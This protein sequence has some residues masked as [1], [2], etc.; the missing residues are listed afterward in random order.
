MSGGTTGAS[1]PTFY[2]A[3]DREVQ[4]VTMARFLYLQGLR[5]GGSV[6]LNSK[7]PLAAFAERYRDFT[8]A[9]VDATAA[10][11]CGRSFAPRMRS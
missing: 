5:P 2:T 8:L 4:A 3:W 9:V 7:E 6:L 1:R 11:P 10:A